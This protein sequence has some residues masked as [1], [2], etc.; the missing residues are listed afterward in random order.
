MF[1]ENLLGIYSE[2]ERIRN[3]SLELIHNSDHHSKYL[4]IIYISLDTIFS[5]NQIYNTE[6][7]D[8]LCL[9]YLGI[10]IFNSVSSIIKLLLSGYYQ[11][12]FMIMRDILETGFLIDYFTIDKTLIKNWR[13]S[14]EKERKEAFKPFVIREALDKRDGFK[15]KKRYKIYSIYSE[16]A[17]HPSFQGSKLITKDGLGVIGPFNDTKLLKAGFEDLSMYLPYFTLMYIS[18]FDNDALF[19]LK[20]NFINKYNVGEEE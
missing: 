5:L 1:L 17:S 7:Q 11:N 9:Q 14:T 18:L 16:Y 15:T 8:E 20:S 4:E 2:E 6:D 12:A 13:T 19:E 3:I 10:R